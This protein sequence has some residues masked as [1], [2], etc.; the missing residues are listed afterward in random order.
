ML[1]FNII[2]LKL[3]YIEIIKVYRYL[4]LYVIQI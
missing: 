2:T 4:F 1:M 3:Q